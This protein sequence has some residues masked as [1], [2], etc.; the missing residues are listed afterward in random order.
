MSRRKKIQQRMQQLQITHKQIAQHV[1]LSEKDLIAWIEC[2]KK[3]PYSTVWKVCDLLS[4][5]IVD[6]WAIL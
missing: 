5:D 2:K 3:L 4:C 1:M 6:L